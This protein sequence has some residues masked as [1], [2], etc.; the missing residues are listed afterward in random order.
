MCIYR[1]I[2]KYLHI[3]TCI[4]LYIYKYTYISTRIDKYIYTY[5][6]T[7]IHTYIH[8]YIYIYIYI[9]NMYVWRLWQIWLWHVRLLLIGSMHTSA[10]GWSCLGPGPRRRL[11]VTKCARNLWS[12]VSNDWPASLS[13]STRARWR[14]ALAAVPSIASLVF[15]WCD[16]VDC[17]WCS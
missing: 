15:W 6:Y 9:Y 16:S 14:T 1:Y 3:H 13:V 5:I 7:H 17:S 10:G 2:Y 4:I 11:R 12:G 8:T